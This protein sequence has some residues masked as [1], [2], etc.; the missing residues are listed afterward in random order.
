M[1]ERYWYSSWDGFAG[2]DESPFVVFD[3][4]W[5]STLGP[6]AGPMVISVDA[7]VIVFFFGCFDVGLIFQCYFASLVKSREKE[8]RLRLSTLREFRH[9]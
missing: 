4:G 8:T 7:I 9:S 1:R 3:V 2:G 6:L 5:R